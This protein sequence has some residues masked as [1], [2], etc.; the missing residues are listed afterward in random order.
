MTLSKRLKLLAVFFSFVL[1]ASTS[2]SVLAQPYPNKI[3]R[4]LVGYPPGGSLDALA[5]IIGQKLSPSL[6][7]QVIVENRA[8]AGGNIAAELV[9]KAQPDGYTL[10]M[11][12]APHAVNPSLYR[13]VAYDPVKDFVAITQITANDFVLVVHPSVPVKTLKEFIALAKAKNGGL[14]YASGGI[15]TAGHLGMEL[16]KPLAGFEAV[17]VPYKGGGPA[18]T[19]VIAGQVDAYILTPAVALPHLRSGK[20]R[21]IAATGPK[22]S[23]LLPDVATIAEEGFPG[24]EVSGWQGLV[25][26]AG[27]PPAIVAKLHQEISKILKLPDVIDRIKA[28]GVEVVG[29]TPEE[30]AAYIQAEVTRYEKVIKRAG[31][32][33]E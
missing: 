16:L 26:S 24:Y 20:I 2:T 14:T 3:I 11:V 18:I 19:D 9:A 28:S 29:S 15:G 13:S 32:K 1:F 23:T 12:A 10:L 7:Q 27:T 8:G 25:A 5:R 22:R 21:A 6:G 4:V 17:H 31:A 33:A 30:F